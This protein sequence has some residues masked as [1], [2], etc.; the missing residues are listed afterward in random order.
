MSTYPRW[1]MGGPDDTA[2]RSPA[3]LREVAAGLFVGSALAA[4][5]VDA[6]CAVVR[7]SEHCVTV[8][9]V[10]TLSVLFEDREPIASR[11]LHR[12]VTFVAAHRPTRPVLIQ[13]Y[14]GLSRSASLAYAVLRVVDGLDH[15]AALARVA[16]AVEHSDRTARFP[17]P[18][19]LAS[20][21]AWCDTLT[22]PA[23]CPCGAAASG[24]RFS[25]AG[26]VAC[27]H[28]HGGDTYEVD[29]G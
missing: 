19:T 28:T 3:L 15:D 4:P 29:R 21:Q 9:Q 8:A 12:A 25:G 26:R 20:A 22:A 5:Y 16:H 27:C 24:T 1:V 7:C 23:M 13:C 2:G 11:V 10:A 17:H 6:E 18:V 14:A